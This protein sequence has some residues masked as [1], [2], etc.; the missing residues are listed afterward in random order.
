MTL[1]TFAISL[2][3]IVFGA[4]LV[5]HF[6][7]P[8]LQDGKTSDTGSAGWFARRMKRRLTF[9]AINGV[10]ALLVIA[11]VVFAYPLGCMLGVPW[12]VLGLSPQTLFTILFVG[13]GV[14]L[15]GVV[16]LYSRRVE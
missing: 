3:L 8:K 13:G 1:S 15:A 6:L 5:G 14:L 12:N 4:A 9:S 10:Y 11:L 7:G 2:V 16:V